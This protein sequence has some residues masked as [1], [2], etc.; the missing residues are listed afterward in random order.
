MEDCT[1]EELFLVKVTSKYDNE[2]N[3]SSWKAY[4]HY[5]HIYKIDYQRLKIDKSAKEDNQII[6]YYRCEYDLHHN[7]DADEGFQ[8]FEVEYKNGRRV[9]PKPLIF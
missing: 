6:F 3:A 1:G 5:Y 8:I 7:E 4:E 9:Y 2:F